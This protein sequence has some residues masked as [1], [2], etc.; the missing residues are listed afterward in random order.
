MQASKISMIESWSFL[1]DSAVSYA[2]TWKGLSVVFRMVWKSGTTFRQFNLGLADSQYS[3]PALT[4]IPAPLST[5]IFFFP[6]RSM[7]NSEEG[8][9]GPEV[10][11]GS[12]DLEDKDW[13]IDFRIL[14]I[15]GETDAPPERD[16]L[17]RS[18]IF[19]MAR[20]LFTCL[21]VQ[22]GGKVLEFR[23]GELCSYTRRIC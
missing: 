16:A 5:T 21:V 2:E 18:L 14:P 13:R 4:E 20:I 23:G 15:R 9:F 11:T 7:L 6:W 19:A 12:F 1:V 17:R 22:R 10:S 3:L 8:V